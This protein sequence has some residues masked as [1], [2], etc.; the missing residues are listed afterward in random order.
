ML[1]TAP[2]LR[3]RP[4]TRRIAREDVILRLHGNVALVAQ[5]LG[6]GSVLP[7]RLERGRR[8]VIGE[9]RI[10]PAVGVQESF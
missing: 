3:V 4:S 5:V 9:L 10:T 2:A 8:R 1:A 7:N 6:K